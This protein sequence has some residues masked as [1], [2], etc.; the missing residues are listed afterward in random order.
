MEIKNIPINLGGLKIN[1]TTDYSEYYDYLCTHFSKTILTNNPSNFDI[2]TEIKWIDS[3]L[4]L[5]EDKKQ[6]RIAANTFLTEDTIG[7]IRKIGKKKKVKFIFGLKKDKITVKA[8][9]QYKPLKDTF[10]YRILA[11]PQ[12]SFFFALTYPLV[13][14]PLFW[15]LENFRNIYTLHAG[16]ISVKDNGIVIC[17]LEGVGKT[18]LSLLL[19]KELGAQFLSDNIIFYDANYVYPCYEPVRLHKNENPYLWEDNFN[20]INKFKTLKDFYEPKTVHQIEACPKIFIF[21]VF[22]NSFSINE[23]SKQIAANRLLYLNRLAQELGDYSEYASLLNL[24]RL[25]RNR[26]ESRQNTLTKLLDAAKCYEINMRK[27]DGLETNVGKIRQMLA[28]DK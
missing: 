12:E 28:L 1:I 21:P 15:Y 24:L 16:A 18:S 9:T 13:Y 17:G 19:A 8:Q 20:R 3:T 4:S 26:Y 6:K 23:I 7:T 14:Y 27:S 2:E 5:E 22:S 11:K 10:R 25:E